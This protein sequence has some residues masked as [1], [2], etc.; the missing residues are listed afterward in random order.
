MSG[1]RPALESL[2][3]RDVPAADFHT[4]P[5]F[6]AS[7]PAV[8]DHVREIA[9]LGQALGRRTDAVVKLGDSNSSLFGGSTDYLEPLGPG[10]DP[11]SSGLAS[12]G[13]N[14]V[15]TWAAFRA[16]GSYSRETN[17]AYP[18]Y[19]LDSVFPYLA[20]EIPRANPS[21]ALIMLGTNDAYVGTTPDL[22]EQRL[23][24]LIS[25]LSQSG[26]VPILSTIPENL[27]FGTAVT[28]A[29][30][31][32]NQ[33]IANVAESS[34]V[35]LW[36]FHRQL[37]SLP[38]AGLRYD[39]L[40]LNVSPSGGAHFIGYDALYGQNVHN[41]GAI[42]MLDWYRRNVVLAA[43]PFV[44]PLP[45][46]TTLAGHTVYA[47]GRDAG[48]GPI[49]SVYD[50]TTHAE[51]DRFLAFESSFTGGVRVASADVNGDS[52]PDIV[53]GAGPTGGPVIAIFSGADGSRLATFA[54][55]ESSFRGG[56]GSVAA[57]DLDGDGLAEIAVGAGNGGGP[58]IAIYEG[59]TFAERRRFLAYDG[60]FR[61]GVNV[62][63]GWFEGIGATIV[64]GAGS[65]GGP[66]VRFFNMQS[67]API[68]SYFSDSP[69]FTGGVVVAA[70]DLDGDGFD[71]LATARATGGSEITII[72]AATLKEL[73]RIPARTANGAAGVR[74]GMIRN[75][76]DDDLL[77]GNGSGATVQVQQYGDWNANPVAL[78]PND[79]LRAYGVFVG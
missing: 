41:L 61:G 11:V 64:A 30:I 36:N 19:R 60:D 17:L 67:D 73:R 14:L 1:L 56:V 65:G 4:L 40:H 29:A 69:L 32:L 50:A 48:Q 35:P 38:L 9:A 75:G 3:T 7:D 8:L 49:V 63:L 5:I 76:T 46:W 70:G 34:R 78:P 57:R 44:P 45:N 28:N 72:D 39:L 33:V 37:E 79:P 18:G 54:A 20:S 16:T 23:E 21:V 68:R 24:S 43:A 31:A 71:E 2:E 66:N 62:T 53:C 10:F 47:V 22:F 77:I 26:V 51:L 58:V 42:V 27:A 13:Q 25:Q 15:D 55:F 52:I 59:G 74:L 6:P 12:L